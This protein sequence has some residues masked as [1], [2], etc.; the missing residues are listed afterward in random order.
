MTLILDL[1]ERVDSE[2]LR[3]EIGRSY[4][5]VGSTLVRTHATAGE[6]APAENTMR[7]LVKL[8]TRQYL[9]AGEEG[10][11]ELWNDVM[12]DWFRN[13]FRKLGNQALIYNKRQK[14][15][16]DGSELAFTWLEVDLQNG[17]LLVR[18]HMNDV[19]GIAE[20]AAD[21]LSLVRDAYNEGKLG[22]AGS[23]ARVSMR[24][25]PTI[26]PRRWKPA[27]PRSRSAR[28]PRRLPPPKPRQLPKPSAPP[29]RRPRPRRSW[30][31]PSWW[32]PTRG[33]LTARAPS[34]AAAWSRRS[35]CSN[36]MS[37]RSRRRTARGPWSI[38]TARARCSRPKCLL[39]G[40]RARPAH[41]LPRPPEGAACAATPSPPFENR[42]A[43]CH[44]QATGPQIA[45]TEGSF[46]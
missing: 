2:N 33:P 31:R 8:S 15:M 20:D 39:R 24:P 37:L 11:D 38:L 44:A 36:L 1:D 17:T 19:S 7:M 28:P 16:E 12:R 22:D 35:L 18:L 43:A 29:L 40:P 25:P 41:E 27:Q 32:R 45:A 21:M 5:Y 34:M 3:L 6:D 46:T 13:Q 30:S 23:I 14:E 26:G 4:A 42:P 9:A 10:S